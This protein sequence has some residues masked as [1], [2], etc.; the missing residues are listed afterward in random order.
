MQGNVYKNGHNMIWL[1]PYMYRILAK[2]G[3]LRNIGPPSSFF[4][5]FSYYVLE[6]EILSPVVPYLI[7][8]HIYQ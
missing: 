4:P 3:P 8:G 6:N 7:A 2:E 5:H 1:L